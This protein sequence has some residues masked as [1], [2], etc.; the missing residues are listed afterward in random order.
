MRKTLG[1]DLAKTTGWSVFRNKKLSSYGIIKLDKNHH[2]QAINTFLRLL[3]KYKPDVIVVEHISFSPRARALASY[4]RIRTVLEVALEETGYDYADIRDVTPTEL[5]KFATESGKASKADMCQAARKRFR[6][7]LWA[8]DETPPDDRKKAQ[9]KREED[10]A[11]GIWVGC[12][13]SQLDK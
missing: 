7:D 3:E 5:K 12:W 4:S 10:M 11:D 1:F 13:G 8:Q 9:R 6:V 2:R